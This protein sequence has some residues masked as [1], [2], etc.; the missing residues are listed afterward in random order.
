MTSEN[1]LEFIN[2]VDQKAIGEGARSA[3]HPHN[4][5]YDSVNAGTISF[6]RG[7]RHPVAAFFHYAFKLAALLVYLFGGLF[8]SNF[9]LICVTCILLLAFDFWTVKNIS[10]RLMVGLR[11][12]SSVN[13]DGSTS[14][15]FESLENLSEIHSVD[16][17][18]FWIGLYSAPIVW[19]VLFVVGVLKFSIQWLVIV[20]VAIVLG[21][22]NVVGYSKC[23]KDAKNKIKKLMQDGAM[24]AMGNAN[25]RSMVF[26]MFTGGEN[27]GR[28]SSSEM[29]QQNTARV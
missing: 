22:A 2:D 4:S 12:W 10:G 20:G 25:L 8:S 29:S 28:N 21:T 3:N 1:E 15:V 11:W 24:A 9:V 13:D 5:Q 6:L 7:A 16:S 26:S 23:S 14:W 19:A 27:K 17:S 18:L